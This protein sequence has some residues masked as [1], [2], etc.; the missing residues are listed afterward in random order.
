MYI[1]LLVQYPLVFSD[2]NETNFLDR[3]SKN[4]QKS[5][6]TKILPASAEFFPRG[7]MER[8][9]DKQTDRETGRHDESYSRFSRF[10]ERA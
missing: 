1:S 2:F 4:I 7:R 6:F 8:Q 10:C 5:N 3:F 9:T